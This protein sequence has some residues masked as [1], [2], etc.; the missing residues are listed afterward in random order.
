MAIVLRQG[1]NKILPGTRPSERNDPAAASLIVVEMLFSAFTLGLLFHWP[2]FKGTEWMAAA[3]RD[4]LIASSLRSL[5]VSIYKKFKANYPDSLE[6][7][8]G[9]CDSRGLFGICKNI[10]LCRSPE[11]AQQL[12]EKE[13]E[14]NL[15]GTVPI[16]LFTFAIV[17]ILAVLPSWK[18]FDL[19]LAGIC[20]AVAVLSIPVF[21]RNRLEEEANCYEIYRLLGTDLLKDK[22]EKVG[23]S[24]DFDV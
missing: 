22:V 1:G 12:I 23:D 19:W 13:N 15:Y 5:R 8:S 18:P 7:R 2:S 21:R 3:L 24:G 17:H 4:R 10:I 9:H 6:G 16:P 11:L 20:L 14:I